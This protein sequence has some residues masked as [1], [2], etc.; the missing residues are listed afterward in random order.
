MPSL[1]TDDVI[2]TAIAAKSRAMDSGSTQTV[3]VTEVAESIIEAADD[4]L[5]TVTV[6]EG[7]ATSADIQWVMEALR[8]GGYT[9]T[10]STT[11]L[12]ISW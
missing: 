11:N 9:V 6:A 12:V 5:F 8:K 10:T 7:G 4:G 2:P 1:H 3:L